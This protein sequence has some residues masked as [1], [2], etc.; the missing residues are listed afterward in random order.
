MSKPDPIGDAMQAAVANGVF[1]G[2]VLFVRL[3]GQVACHQAFG[4]AALVPAV[5]PACLDTLY[6]L[7]S[8]TKPL[9]TVTTV[10]L[11][12]RD[13]RLT[14]DDLVKKHVPECVGHP[15]GE[16]TIWHLLTHSSGLPSWRPFYERIAQEDQLRPGLL[17]SDAAR[18]RMLTLIAEEPLEYP[19]GTRSVYSDLGFML[20]GMVVERVTGHT[21]EAYCREQV[22]KPMQT[23]LMF[24]G[25]KGEHPL[26]LHTIAPTEQES[27][28]GRLLRGEVHDE[29]AHALGGVSGHAGLFGTAAA[30]ST[31]TGQ[32]LDSYVGRGWLL[33]SE[34]VRKFV[35]KQ[36]RVTGSSWALGWD[37][38]SAPSSSGSRFSPASFG[39]LG[40]TGTSIWI[41]PQAELEVILLSNRVHP[42][43]SN[44]A[45]KLFRPVIH[46]LIYKELVAGSEQS[47]AGNRH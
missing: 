47:T 21:L 41:D 11:L 34:L 33:P 26:D 5:E 15:I 17:G 19:A 39:H 37:T 44:E 3:R 12:V 4:N 28:R 43:R 25:A 10:L 40:Y 23:P 6:D 24:L 16:L 7:A 30:V 38:P 29:N 46:D 9:A 27:W 8:L 13:G 35:T 45:I 14:L 2:A 20:L 18:A 1:P 36:D 42:S 22:F 31:V 32:W